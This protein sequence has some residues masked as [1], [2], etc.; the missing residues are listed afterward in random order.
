MIIAL[1][2]RNLRHQRWLLIGL[3]LGLIA[4][5]LLLIRVGAEF[6]S[7]TQLQQLLDLMPPF[8]RNLIGS[9]IGAASFPAFVA[10]TF[11]HPAVIGLSLA[12]SVVAGTMPA[13]ERDAGTLDL[14]LARPLPRAH[15]IASVVLTILVDGIILSA[16]ILT[17][18]IIGLAIVDAPEELPW[19]RYVVSAVS[20]LLLNLAIAGSALLAAVLSPRRGTAVAWMVALVFVLYVVEV[21][22]DLWSPLASVRW[23]SPFHY[24]KP[25]SAV[26]EGHAP[27]RNP[28]I[29]IGIFILTSGGAIAHF[30]RREI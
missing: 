1:V 27:V 18:I 12:F 20:F 14:L 23:M 29:L 21:L 30:D 2:R 16:S 3:V 26:I 5:A 17:G 11:Q 13:G 28:V 15:Y 19:T 4:W 9:Q 25:V 24:F 10:F 6:A 7:G 22:A 8:V